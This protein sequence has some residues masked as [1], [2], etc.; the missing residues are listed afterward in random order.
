MARFLV[1]VSR[2]S[3]V[4]IDPRRIQIPPTT[5][6]ISSSVAAFSRA[7]FHV[8]F[9]T[10]LAPGNTGE[11]RFVSRCLGCRIACSLILRPFCWLCPIHRDSVV[12]A[13]KRPRGRAR[14]PSTWPAGYTTAYHFMLACPSTR[15]STRAAAP[16]I[17]ASLTPRA[18]P[19]L[20]LDAELQPQ[21]AFLEELQAVAE[22]VV[23]AIFRGPNTHAWRPQRLPTGKP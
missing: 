9:I 15:W 5:V 14:Q 4:T 10:C 8:R 3:V 12:D 21:R 6:L 23:V 16:D 1:A 18:D 2:S 13:A 19:P 7:Q 22:A 17:P 20:G 11:G